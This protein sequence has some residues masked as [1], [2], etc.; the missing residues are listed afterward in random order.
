MDA[1]SI[2]A[3]LALTNGAAAA[4]NTAAEA[5]NSAASAAN[6]AAAAYPNLGKDAVIDRTAFNYAWTMMQ[7]EMRDTRKRLTATE[8]QLAALT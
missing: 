5:A 4:A 7:A 6:A 3:A 8:A 1:L 2:G